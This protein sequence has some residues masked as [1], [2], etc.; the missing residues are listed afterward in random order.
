[1]KKFVF[2]L[3]FLFSMIPVGASATLL[4]NG[5]LDIDWSGPMVGSYFGD[6][7]AAEMRLSGLTQ[8]NLEVFC[9]QG[10]GASNALV[11]YT[12][13]SIS[14]QHST[15]FDYAKISKAA[16]IADNW[17]NW[18]TATDTV[19]DKDMKKVEAQKAVWLVTGVMDVVGND[20]L[21]RTLYNSI[22]GNLSGYDFSGWAYAYNATYQDFLVPIPAVPEP[23]T[24]LLLGIGLI[25]LAG[26]GRKKLFNK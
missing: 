23:T 10:Q 26:F 17:T 15:I 16:W 12:F 1:M 22:P 14:S 5:F 24:M 6:Y 19:G 3:V 20:G 18:V 8:K 21:D 9:V 13:Y 7:D 4:G 25:G 2:I 11:G